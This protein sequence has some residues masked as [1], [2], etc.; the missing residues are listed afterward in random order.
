MCNL[1]ILL[2]YVL[3]QQGCEDGRVKQVAQ[4]AFVFCG[5]CHGLLVRQPMYVCSCAQEREQQ[6]KTC[7]VQALPARLCIEAHT[8]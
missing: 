6:S 1:Y 5:M 7:V 2:Q 8:H 3:L 4:E